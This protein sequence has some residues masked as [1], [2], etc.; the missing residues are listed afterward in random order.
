MGCYADPNVFSR[1]LNGL[2][3]L[4]ISSKEGSGSIGECVAKCYALNFSYAGAQ[5]G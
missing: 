4:G 5:F 3:S 1:D 2:D